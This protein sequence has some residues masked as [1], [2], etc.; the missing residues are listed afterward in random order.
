MV[1]LIANTTTKT[2]LTIR[3]ALHP[4]CSVL[5]QASCT[6]LLDITREAVI[7]A[8]GIAAWLSCNEAEVSTA[9]I[10]ISPSATSRCSL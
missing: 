1:E 7:V 9:L 2:G 8:S 5:G 6:L 4:P 10:G 3:W